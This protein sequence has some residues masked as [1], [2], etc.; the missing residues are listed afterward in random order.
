LLSLLLSLRARRGTALVGFLLPLCAAIA[1]TGVYNWLRFGS[2]FDSGYDL[3][4]ERFDSSFL[5]GVTKLVVSP[6][7]GLLIFWPPLLLAIAGLGR[8]LRAA[9]R[10]TALFVGSFLTLLL[11]YAKWWA[12]S[13]F[14]WGPRFLVPAIPLLALLALPV[15][16]SRRRAE[17]ALTLACLMGGIAVQTLVATTSHWQQVLYGV[18]RLAACPADGRCMDDPRVAPLRVALWRTQATWLRIHD[19]E[20]FAAH[21]Q[22][23]P[24][25][26]VYP[27]REPERAAELQSANTGLDLW[28]APV[29]WRLQR[30]YLWLPGNDAPILASTPL[31]PV[32]VLLVGGSLVV[33]LRAVKGS[34]GPA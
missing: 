9:P 20:R 24:W 1:L 13:G 4:V 7:Y 29:R 6:S 22:A 31:V 30:F 34:A 28:A 12:F 2:L 10:E 5:A 33:V 8:Q 11:L 32:L 21:A 16:R 18:Y 14:G 3:S 23:P 19:P 25:V 26:D 17:R 27:W 15:V